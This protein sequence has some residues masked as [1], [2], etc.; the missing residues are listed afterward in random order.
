MKNL[1][2]VFIVCICFAIT[3]CYDDSSA[4]Q[5]E[6]SSSSIDLFD[7]DSSEL[8]N[9][10]IENIDTKEIF[11]VK[12]DYH[13]YLEEDETIWLEHDIQ[14][15]DEPAIE[16]ISGERTVITTELFFDTSSGN[17]N[18]LTIT[19]PIKKLMDVNADEH[20]PPLLLFSFS[21]RKAKVVME[22]MELRLTEFNNKGIPVAATMKVIFKLYTSSASQFKEKPRH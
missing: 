8:I 3:G 13:T 17:T 10:T 18:V 4:S 11:N 5:S 2:F 9:A 7:T 12:F 14:G 1:M 19:N 16:F 20:R 6:G 22:K 21:G 15:L